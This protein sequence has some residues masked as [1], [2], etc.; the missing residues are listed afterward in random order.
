MTHVKPVG[1]IGGTVWLVG[2]IA[3]V[4]SDEKSALAAVEKTIRGERE[5]IR[6]NAKLA[7]IDLLL[8]EG[9]VEFALDLFNE[10]V[11]QCDRLAFSTTKIRTGTESP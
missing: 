2:G 6:N 11:E 9:Q 3:D 8:R 7:A 10:S 5:R 4:Y 1:K